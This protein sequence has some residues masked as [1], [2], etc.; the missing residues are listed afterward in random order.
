MKTNV[1]VRIWGMTAARVRQDT[2]KGKVSLQWDPAM[3]KGRIELS[4][5]PGGG[6]ETHSLGDGLAGLPA[7]VLDSIPG[8][9]G[10]PAPGHEPW[11]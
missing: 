6:D 11:L 4:P 8:Q 10:I 5:L 2:S 9:W 7:V 3:E 1:R